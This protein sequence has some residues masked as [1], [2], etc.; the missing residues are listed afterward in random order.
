MFFK[1]DKAKAFSACSY[2]WTKMQRRGSVKRWYSSIGARPKRWVPNFFRLENET[3]QFL[4]ITNF[5]TN[6]RKAANS[7]AMDLLSS[8]GRQILLDKETNKSV[9]IKNTIQKV[10]GGPFPYYF[11]S[12]R[13]PKNSCWRTS[14]GWNKEQPFWAEVLQQQP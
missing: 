9:T 1:K 7:G 11:K 8:T 13:W 10:L 12:G 2:N 5:I 3:Y 6:V 14:F 4:A